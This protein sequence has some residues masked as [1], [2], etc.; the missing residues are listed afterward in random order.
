MSGLQAHD[1][2]LA[3]VKLITPAVFEDERG[4]FFESW[5]KFKFAELGIDA[6]FLQ[7][8]QSFSRRGTLRGVHLQIAHPQGKL[9][10]VCRGEV[11]DVAVDLRPDSP[12]V[13]QW[14]GARLS[15][16]NHHMLWIPPGLGHAFLVLS[17]EAVFSY[18]CTDIYYPDDQHTLA[19]DDPDVAIDW[20]AIEGVD[21]F[22]LSDKDRRGQSLAEILARIRSAG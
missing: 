15:D 6:E 3:G 10:Q 11:F 12:T 21:G 14:Y 16:R 20:P 4:Y 8:N 7:D 9:V 13:G 2:G 1:T 19:W 5:Q 17:D 18:K 22:V